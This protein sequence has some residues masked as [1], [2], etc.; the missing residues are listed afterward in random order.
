MTLEELKNRVRVRH[1]K[2]YCSYYV[3]ITY[4]GKEYT[5]NSNNSLAWDRLDDENF[6]DNETNGFYTT[7]TAYQAFY[8][9]CKRKNRLG[10]YSYY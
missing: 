1:S 7:K 10:E 5:C 3:K 8:D 9:E 2:G 4:R 6:R